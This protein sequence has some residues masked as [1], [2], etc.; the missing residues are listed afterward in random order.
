MLCL[1]V[2]LF[3]AQT[4]QSHIIHFHVQ[5]WLTKDNIPVIIHGGDN[6]ELNHSINGRENCH[7]FDCM[8]E[9]LCAQ[10]DIGEGQTIP[11]LDMLLSEFAGT[12]LLLNIELKAP[13]DSNIASRYN[14]R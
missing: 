10:I 12:S 3:I 7:V 11:T 4:C 2:C 6:G 14:H 9:D 5:I 13:I 8:Y 1:F